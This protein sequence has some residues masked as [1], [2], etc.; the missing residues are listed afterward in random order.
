M[1]AAR[2]DVAVALEQDVAAVDLGAA[3]DGRP[4]VGALQPQIG[5]GD[6]VREVVLDPQ[7]VVRGDLDVEA[8]RQARRRR[9]APTAGRPRRR[10]GR[11]CSGRPRSA[12]ARRRRGRRPTPPSTGADDVAAQPEVRVDVRAEALRD[13]GGAS[14]R[15]R[16]SGS[17]RRGTNPFEAD[18]PAE[19][20]LA[21]GH[22]RGQI[23]QADAACRRT[24]SM[25][26]IASSP[27]GSRQV[28]DAAVGDART[29]GKL[30]LRERSVDLGLAA[31]PCRGCAGCGRTPGGCRGSP[32]RW[33]R[34]RPC[35]RAAARCR[36]SAAGCRRRRRAA[37]RSRA[38]DCSSDSSI[39]PSLARA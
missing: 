5:A 19:H 34:P 22:A 18:P 35:R 26:L 16:R 7:R 17:A 30:R 37:G 28:P 13:S 23:L 12:A 29:A 27:C 9:P 33:L 21:T 14:V 32:R 31:P 1:R 24:R 6:D 25:P 15:R 38:R 8:E 11:R 36:P 39:G 4:V 2:H 10:P 20:D 3:E